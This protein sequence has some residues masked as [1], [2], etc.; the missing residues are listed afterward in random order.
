M[1]Q[2]YL[3]SLE[4]SQ[5]SPGSRSSTAARNKSLCLPRLI[6]AANDPLPRGCVCFSPAFQDVLLW[7]RK[8]NGPG[9]VQGDLG[10]S[11]GVNIR[12]HTHEQT[13]NEPP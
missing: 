9:R 3:V 2:N 10:R 13:S 1:M 8:K 11:K 5:A 12:G 7:R 4:R 6:H